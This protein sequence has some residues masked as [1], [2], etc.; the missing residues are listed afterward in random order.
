M[1]RNAF[2]IRLSVSLMLLFGGIFVLR[3]FK[4]DEILIDQLA[5]VL[6]GMFLLIGSLI[7]RRKLLKKRK[8]KYI[9]K[10]LL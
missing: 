7:W 2:L 1:E 8:S 6:V 5:G 10:T 4:N 3:Y 9:D